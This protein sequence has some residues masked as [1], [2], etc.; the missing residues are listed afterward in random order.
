MNATMNNATIYAIDQ[1]RLI[2]ETFIANAATFGNIKAAYLP[3]SALFVDEN[4]Q[5]KPQHK[6]NRIAANWDDN[7]CGFLEVSYRQET[8]MFAIIDGQNRFMAGKIA[9]RDR[10]PCHIVMDIDVLE[11]ARRFAKQDENKTI[12]STFDK[13][14][15]ELFSGDPDAML[16][17]SICDKFNIKIRSSV[18]YHTGCLRSITDAK[19]TLKSAGEK[20]LS[21]CFSVIKE[22]GWHNVKNAY[23]YIVMSALRNVFMSIDSD[24]CELVKKNLVTYF[25]MTTPDHVMAQSTIAFR[26]SGRQA[27]L[28]RFLQKI[29]VNGCNVRFIE[30]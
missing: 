11:E 10:F 25:S 23:H 14:K 2:N 7:K 29:G 26:D 4:Y 9:G 24:D 16:L 19:R 8:G 6:L 27:A 3:A 15:A 21:W 20:G 28:T 22:A 17:K 13:F 12:V 5:R 1:K 30:Q 18:N